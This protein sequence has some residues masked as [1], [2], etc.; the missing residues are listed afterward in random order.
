V[1]LRALKRTP[2]AERPMEFYTTDACCPACRERHGFFAPAICGHNNAS[3][4][5]VWYDRVTCTWT[6]DSPLA[7]PSD[8][9]PARQALLRRAA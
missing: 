7:A 5:D 1:R 4:R 6:I 8:D 9:D 3:G 2:K